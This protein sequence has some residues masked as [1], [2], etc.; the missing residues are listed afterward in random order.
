MKY[1]LSLLLCVLFAPAQQFLP[2]TILEYSVTASI[3]EQLEHITG[4]ASVWV[5]MAADSTASCTFRVN[6]ATDV[7]AVRDIDDDKFSVN[8]TISVDNSIEYTIDF[9]NYRFPSDSVFL[10]IE[11]EERIDSLSALPMFINSREFILPYTPSYA[12]L[13]VFAA[14]AAGTTSLEITL[15]LAYSIISSAAV[16]SQASDKRFQW[17]VSYNSE[18]IL[19]E[20]FSLCGS[21]AIDNWEKT[22]N[23]S[24]ASVSF[25]VST[26]AF[27]K[28]FADSLLTTLMNANE[29]YRQLF[30][31]DTVPSVMNYL[32]IGNDPLHN[33]P[34]RAG[35]SVI[36]RNSPAYAVFDSSAFT[37]SISNPWLFEL[38]LTWC[39]LSNDSTIL[40]T[41]GWAGYL[42]Y[43]YLCSL[44][45]N[46]LYE[47]R[48]RLDL[49][50]RALSFYP[51]KAVA[52][53]KNL[54]TSEQQI[55]SAKVEYFFLM[56]D[57][58]LGREQFDTVIK[59]LYKKSFH[60]QILRKDFQT[61]CEEAYGSSLEWFFDQWLN[62]PGIPEFVLEWR[63][64][65]TARG[66]VRIKATVE[67][68]GDI[69]TS[70]MD[71]YFSAGAKT[72]PKR[73]IVENSKQEFV[74]EFSSLPSRVELD[75]D[76]N[77]LRW[78][79]DIRILAHARSSL[80]FLELRRDTSSSKREAALALQLDPVNATGAAPIAYYSLGTIAAIQNKLEQA[81]EYF[82]SAMQSATVEESEVF[83]LLSVVRYANILEMEGKRIE[84]IP[85]YQRVLAEGKKNP[86]VSAPAMV[87]A[88]KYLQENFVSAD[89]VW[90]GVY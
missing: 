88:E 58:L 34:L 22:S 16:E 45:Q 15:P 37:R 86:L 55:L 64:E 59:K 90:Y 39:P 69:F 52:M 47:R 71:V 42:A 50:V 53:G 5:R 36:L 56:L 26:G 78:L 82:F 25:I 38:A 18:A 21:V 72:I 4:T 32:F 74:F 14:S 77:I 89:D 40:F 35:N 67:Q 54:Q 76:L 19:S 63:T 81:R 10:K 49:M 60:Q 57:Y 8:R 65:K 41:D 46:P 11:F 23:D 12:W 33:K 31:A 43:R 3:D 9:S 75:P 7:D 48:E 79:I 87:E 28:Q 66:M 20:A 83:T 2:I 13:P 27:N 24:L 68:R 73:I 1:L 62:R 80:Q 84:A 6:T 29:Y 30:E 85:L 44:R 17:N 51:A 61:L 70:P